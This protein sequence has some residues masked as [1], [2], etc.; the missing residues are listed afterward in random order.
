[1]MYHFR[2]SDLNRRNI[3]F[4]TFRLYK[5]LMQKLN[6][7]TRSGRAED[8]T[9]LF[10]LGIQRAGTSLMYWI[11]ERDMNA[12][13]Y[14]ES[15][16]LNS[17]DTVEH[18]RLDPLPEV[19]AHVD[20]N[21]VPLIVL[22]PLVESQRFHEL[23]SIFPGSKALWQYRHYQ[24]VAAS[25][26]KAFGEDNG[27]KD[28][29]PLIDND[30]S[31][32]RSQNSAAETRETIRRFFREDMNPY[33]AAA[34]F[35]WAR[36]RLYFDLNLVQNPDVLPCRYEDLA[37]DPAATMRRIYTFIDVPY[38]GDHIVRDVHPQ[39][40]GKGRVSRLS[41]EVDQLCAELLSRLDRLNAQA[42][43][44]FSPVRDASEALLA[45]QGT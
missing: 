20:R 11:F 30:R 39:S 12:R 29:R 6:A 43:R 40:V 8:K 7:A 36:C 16:E 21:N 38:P 17:Q 9:I 13:I 45:P 35:W 32:W 14:R 15:S 18:V 34:L 2:P 44:K 24:D 27:V 28:L 5:G 1:M 26:I 25:N 22:K 4:G 19:K 10:I 37:I 42:I 23:A 3:E 41:P 31:N 33:D